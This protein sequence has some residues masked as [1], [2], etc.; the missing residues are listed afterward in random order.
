M[1]DFQIRVLVLEDEIPLIKD[2][3]DAFQTLQRDF[4]AHPKA[5]V[6]DLKLALSL[7]Q[8]RELMTNKH[9]HFTSLDLRVPS[10]PDGLLQSDTTS[11]AT[12]EAIREDNRVTAAAV[13]TQFSVEHQES[14][15]HS[16]RLNMAYW[17]KSAAD[18]SPNID[19]PILTVNQWAERVCEWITPYGPSQRHVLHQSTMLLPKPMAEVCTTLV[20]ACAKEDIKHLSGSGAALAQG[21]R[22]ANQKEGLQAIC[23]LS[24]LVKEWLWALLAARVCM[25]PSTGPMMQAQ[26]EAIQNVGRH[27]W[28]DGDAIESQSLKETQLNDLIALLDEGGDQVNPRLKQHLGGCKRY[29]HQGDVPFVA[30]LKTIRQTRNRLAHFNPNLDFSHEWA[31]LALPFWRVLD[32]VAYF[33]T[34]PMI[35]E[36]HKQADGVYLTKLLDPVLA[37]SKDRKLSGEWASANGQLLTRNDVYAVW[38]E[39]VEKPMLLPLSPWVDRRKNSN[40]DWATYLYMGR[41]SQRKVRDLDAYSWRPETDQRSTGLRVEQLDGSTT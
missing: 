36:V 33:A 1:P 22:D 11:L 39:S 20:N 17:R 12:F 7:T 26:R 18:A 27:G 32:V 21:W 8:F 5:L 2:M 10:E 38:P 28:A 13:Y 24:E 37:S 34:F 19:P 15:R 41:T 40:G 30:A 16:E 3:R 6:P 14:L 31:E 4:S 23:R 25:G 29:N 35:T 9:Y